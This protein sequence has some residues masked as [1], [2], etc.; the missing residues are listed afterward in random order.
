MIKSNT[1]FAPA[2]AFF[3]TGAL[4]VVVQLAPRFPLLLA[5]RFLPGAGWVQ[6]FFMAVYSAFLTREFL[7]PAR[8]R[9]LRPLIWLG[10]SIVFF[11]QLLIGLAGFE[12]FL[13]TGKL[14]LP[15]PALIVAGPLYR[16]ADFFMPI[17][18]LGTILLV[19]PAWC[20][21]LCYIGAW[22]NYFSSSAKE[23]KPLPRWANP[24]RAI[25]LLLTLVL[26]LLLRHFG[27][28]TAIALGIA[29]LFGFCS[30]AVMI[31]FSRRTGSLLHCQAICP[32]G[33]I[34]GTLGRISPFRIRIG[35]ECNGCM[36]CARVCRYHALNAKTIAARR[37]GFTCTLCGDC[38]SACH[39]RQINYRLPF[40]SAHFSRQ[41]FIV[42]IIS[43]HSVFL[44]VAR[45]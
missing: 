31:F 30:I 18:L 14:H 5:E 20:S 8:A 27:V 43:L 29:V 9:R 17:L 2:V 6:I 35:E 38:V 34:T 1:S 26:P 36:A 16:G 37:P 40:A 4:L 44:A 42:L 32:I 28:S 41:A 24:A 10:F 45:I 21:H 33:L 22:D 25:T 7:D 19:G 15:V 11:S 39:R 13:M 12:K 23:K 3:L